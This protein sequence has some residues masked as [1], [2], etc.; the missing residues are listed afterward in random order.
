M[1]HQNTH[2]AAARSGLRRSALR[3]AAILGALGLLG[4]ATAASASAAVGAGTTVADFTLAQGNWSQG[5]YVDVLTSNSAA[6]KAGYRI[7]FQTDG[8]VVVYDEGYDVDS[9][10]SRTATWASG[11]NSSVKQLDWS[12][13]G[14]LKLL[15]GSGNVLCRIGSGTP[16]PGGIARLQTD[17]NFVFYTTGGTATWA[18]GTYSGHT[19]TKDACGF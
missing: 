7:W 11:Q 2:P 12:Q 6:I 14:Y 17:G 10:W 8:N 4:A 18:S 13:Y 16:A 3:G 15:D 9:G 19:G 5:T 1:S